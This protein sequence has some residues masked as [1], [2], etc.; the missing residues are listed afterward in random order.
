M[1]RLTCADQDC[2]HATDA[3][4]DDGWHIGEDSCQFCGDWCMVNGA[5][6]CADYKRWIETSRP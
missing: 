5:G 4:F 3:C 1:I 2:A 6:G